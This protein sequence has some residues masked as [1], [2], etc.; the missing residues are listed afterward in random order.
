MDESNCIAPTFTSVTLTLDFNHVRIS[1]F[2]YTYRY[3]QSRT[4]SLLC[5]YFTECRWVSWIAFAHAQLRRSEI[6][7]VLVE[8][9]SKKIRPRIFFEAMRKR[10]AVR[11][12]QLLVRMC[13]RGDDIA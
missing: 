7:A 1:K 8:S 5:P 10:A 4:T 9:A 6:S 3:I 11:S 13:L 12:V 2:L